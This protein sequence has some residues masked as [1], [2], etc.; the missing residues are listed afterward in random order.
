MIGSAKGY[1]TLSPNYIFWPSLCLCLTILGTNLL[2]D[3]LRD[4]LDPKL[5]NEL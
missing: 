3:S 2:G 4:L 5:N 1:I